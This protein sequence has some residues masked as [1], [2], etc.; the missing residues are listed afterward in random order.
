M[1][2]ERGRFFQGRRVLAFIILFET[3]SLLIHFYVFSHM[4][5][6]LDVQTDGWFWIFIIA[7]SVLWLVA[8]GLGMLHASRATATFH[9]VSTFW[10]GLLFMFM[11][12]LIG[13]DAV[14][15]FVDVDSSIVAP[16]VIAIALGAMLYGLMN[17]RFL[18]TKELV[19]TT[20]KIEG[21]VR[22]AHLSD[23]HIGSVYTPAFLQKVVDRTNTLDPDVVLITGDLA[24]GAHEY[25]YET[26]KPLDDLKAPVYFVT[27][28]HEHYAGIDRVLGSLEGTKVQRLMNRMVTENGIQIVGVD[29]WGERNEVAETIDQIDPDGSRFTI[30]MYHVPREL[31]AVRERG[32][33][34]MLAG[35]THGGQFF[36]FPL[37]ARMV[38]KKFRGLYDLGSTQLFV[39]SGIGTWGPPIR[40]GTSSQIGLLRIKGKAGGAT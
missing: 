8:M 39:S 6:L 24:D 14:R 1:S 25:T 36:P 38:W 18:R 15:Q 28:N 34:L 21:E 2:G 37:F 20:D 19:I 4:F 26:W 17:A 10:L 30:L 9:I 7:S 33:D 3:F 5:Y 27:G 11:F 13:W 12:T 31:D 35:H 29:Y 32:V 16:T 40:I 23:I 22:V